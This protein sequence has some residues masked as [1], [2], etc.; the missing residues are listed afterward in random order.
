M[1]QILI[2]GIT[3]QLGRSI[4]FLSKNYK[5]I[6]F[7]FTNTKILNLTKKNE[8]CNFFQ[9]YKFNIIVNC[10]A[11]TNV[12]LAEINTELNYKI[13]AE[14]IKIIA[15]EA[16]KQN[17]ILIHISTDYVFDGKS[18]IPYLPEDIP[19]PIN[20]YG[21][22]KLLG[23]MNALENNI[24]SIIIRTSWLYS[25]YGQNFVKSIKKI[26]KSKKEVYIIGD[27]KGIPTLTYDLAEAILTIIETPKK[28]YGIYH[29]SNSHPT[30]WF[31][32]AS[33]IKK[34]IE[35]N[36]LYI[37]KTQKIHKIT[38]NQYK[39]IAKRPLYSVLDVKKIQKDYFIK[40]Y[41]WKKSLKK[42]LKTI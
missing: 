22:A 38:T 13:N 8:I 6:K 42:I 37:I 11:Y 28:K 35:K 15:Q 39:S 12:D 4:Y 21:K 18:T 29:Y 23:E 41:H 26:F 3:G 7:T 33:E 30:N 25:P 1:L 32:F 36:K 17:A 20:E 27:Q 2:I 24:K 10:S 34:E 31:N 19:N 5:H 16:N 40:I 9:N 14:A